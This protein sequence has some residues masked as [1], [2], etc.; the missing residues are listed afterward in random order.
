MSGAICPLPCT[1]SWSGSLLKTEIILH[2][3][4]HLTTGIVVVTLFT[5]IYKFTW[6]KSFQ[7]KIV[8]ESHVN[9]TTKH[10]VYSL[11]V[12]L[13]VMRNYNLPSIA[14]YLFVNSTGALPSL[15]R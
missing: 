13:F 14:C 9:Y 12:F 8:L 7:T 6:N 11:S 3:L 5:F 2:I 4:L 15:R 1:S 10:C